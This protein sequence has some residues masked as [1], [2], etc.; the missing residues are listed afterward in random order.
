MG[1]HN[2]HGHLVVAILAAILLMI[3]FS[4]RQYLVHLSNYRPNIQ[5]NR[6]LFQDAFQLVAR[7]LTLDHR[8]ESIEYTTHISAP[9]QA[10]GVAACGSP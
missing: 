6:S 10:A 7:E 1:L 4:L 2:K 9:P 3:L 5:Y 8:A